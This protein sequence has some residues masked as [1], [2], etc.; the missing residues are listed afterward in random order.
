MLFCNFRQLARAVDVVHDAM[1]AK[2]DVEISMVLIVQSV[3]VTEPK[4]RVC[5]G[6]VSGKQTAT[7]Q[8]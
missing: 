3:V 4:A 8:S 1:H 2:V 6:A 5:A 7:Q